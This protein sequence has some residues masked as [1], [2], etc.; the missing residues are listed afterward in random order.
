MRARRARDERDQPGR[1]RLSLCGAR[2]RAGRS[3]RRAMEGLDAAGLAERRPAVR[4]DQR[5]GCGDRVACR[6]TRW[7]WRSGAKR[8]WGDCRSRWLWPRAGSIG[9][10]APA[11]PSGRARLLG[12]AERGVLIALVGPLLDPIGWSCALAPAPELTRAGSRARESSSPAGPGP[13]LGAGAP[14]AGAGPPVFGRP[15]PRAS[16][17][18]GAGA[19]NDG[20]AA[21]GSR[22]TWRRAICWCSTACRRLR[23]RRS[24]VA[25]RGCDRRVPRGGTD[26]SR[27]ARQRRREL[28]E[29]LEDWLED[30][31][32]LRKGREHGSRQDRHRG[33]H[34]GGRTHRDRRR[35]GA[36]HA[37]GRR[38]AGAG[39]GCRA[40]VA[41]RSDSR[42]LAAGRW[43][44]WA[45]GELCNVDGELGV[46]VTAP[47]PCRR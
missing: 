43:R 35:A 24:A 44:A 23:R 18:S 17:R 41:G 10:S 46:R 13:G 21:G 1:R 20:F 28:E 42:G 14:S 4:R 5:G 22:P 15:R 16:R 3:R 8:R 38:G 25:R 12:P 30:G 26:R 6:R 45:E 39:A 27:R 40:D 32:N 29:R 11:R 31:P 9:P 19:G 34:L 37:A 33:G 2:R 36:N 7:R 47:P